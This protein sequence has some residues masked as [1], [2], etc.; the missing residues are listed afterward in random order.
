MI[1]LLTV[2]ACVLPTL[3]YVGLIYAADSY[4]KEPLW[5]LTAV[6][7]WGAIPA[8]VLTIVASTF[9]S[10]LFDAV[11]G[12]EWQSLTAAVLLAPVVEETLKGAAL[13]GIILWR[14]HEIDTVLDGII[15]GTMV[16]MG[17]A[18]VENAFY[19]TSEYQSGGLSAWAVNVF[20]RAFIFGLNHALFSSL[21]G[22]GIAAALLS[23]RE[24]VRTLAPVVGWTLAVFLHFI[25]NLTVGTA[26]VLCLIAPLTDWGGVLLM[27][28]IIGWAVRQERVWLQTYLVAELRDGSLTFSQ[29]ELISDV[30]KRRRYL[31]DLILRGEFGRY[32]AA[33]RFLNLCSKLAYQRHHAA[34]HK[35]HIHHPE[36]DFLREEIREASRVL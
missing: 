27:L 20:F 29:Y 34:V 19:F 22:L 14:R 11:V 24:L 7:I 1:M 3:V 17:F 6:F 12:R 4:E 35:N 23:R 26:S 25:H 10:G 9:V 36:I 21:F 2:L 28:T 8:V 18:M 15:Y 33:R 30:S 13:L 32:L 31:L 5:L 16:G